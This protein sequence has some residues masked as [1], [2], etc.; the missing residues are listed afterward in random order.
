MT[1][2]AQN[3]KKPI[4]AGHSKCYTEP[5][6]AGL[7]AGRKSVIRLTT[8]WPAGMMDSAAGWPGDRGGFA[9]RGKSALLRAGCRATPGR[10]NPGTG[11]QRQTAGVRAG[12]GEKVV[13]ETTGARS[14]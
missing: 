6:R 11:P 5:V 3:E 9:L 4:R 13:E 10:G 1:A 2:P 8:P 7:T 14:N 12:K